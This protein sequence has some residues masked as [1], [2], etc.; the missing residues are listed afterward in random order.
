MDPFV[1]PDDALEFEEGMYC[2]MCL[3][4]DPAMSY[5][6]DEFVPE[7]HFCEDCWERCKIQ[8]RMIEEGLEQDPEVEN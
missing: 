6:E 3:V 8:E 5:F 4:E 2:A 7:T 1:N